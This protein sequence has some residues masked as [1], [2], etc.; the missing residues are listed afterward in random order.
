MSNTIFNRTKN[1]LKKATSSL[2]VNTKNR[3]EEKRWIINSKTETEP[4]FNMKDFNLKYEDEALK[5]SSYSNHKKWLS[6]FPISNGSKYYLRHDLKLGIL[7]SEQFFRTYEPVANTVKV[8]EKNYQNLD[9]RIDVLLIAFDLENLPKEWN[10]LGSST[11]DTVRNKLVK[12]INHFKKQSTKVIYYSLDES[13]IYKRVNSVIPET[14]IVLTIQKSSA[15]YFISENVHNNVHVLKLGFNPVIHNPIGTR[16]HK[17]KNKVALYEFW[18]PKNQRRKNTLNSFFTS[19]VNSENEVILYDSLLDKNDKT[20]IFPKELQGFLAPTVN[21]EYKYSYLKFFQSIYMF[22]EYKEKYFPFNRNLMEFMALGNTLITNYHS[23]IHN[24]YPNVYLGY[25]KTEIKE[26]LSKYSDNDIY[27]NQMAGVRNIF[28]QDTVFERFEELCSI[29]KIDFIKR[30]RKIAVIAKAKTD[31]VVEMFNYQTYPYKELILESELPKDIDDQYDMIAFFNDEYQYGEFYLE[32]LV[33]GFKYTFCD[34]I[35]K[36]SKQIK[37]N[38]SS[39][40]DHNYVNVL[41]DKYAT[42]FWSKSFTLSSL[43]TLENGAALSNGYMIDPFELE[44]K[45]ISSTKTANKKYKF[46]MIIPVYNNGLF[47]LNK[48][49]QSL[50]RSSM[51]DEM[52]ILIIDDG[53]TDNFTPNIVKRLNRQYEN[54]RCYFFNDGGSGSASRPRNKGIELITTEFITYLDPDNEAVNDGY[55]KLYNEISTNDFDMAVGNIY[56]VSDREMRLNFVSALKNVNNQQDVIEDT[57]KVFIEAAFKIASIQALLIRKSLIID[58]N[59]EMVVGAAG[60]DSLFFKEL[61]IFSKKIKLV[62][63]DIHIYYADVEGSV[64]NTI[65]ANFFKKYY[66]VQPYQVKFLKEQSLFTEYA[67]RRFEYYFKEWI[68]KKLM[69]VK[70]E[71]ALEAVKYS[72]QIWDYYKDYVNITEPVVA[73]FAELS[74]LKEYDKIVD[75]FVSAK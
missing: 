4:T 62:D 54:V 20:T 14:D 18:D 9:K 7:S 41:S 46:S 44:K 36:D 29:L 11:S 12:L 24:R 25:S 38:E 71:D 28:K 27:E 33:N 66:L 51:F 48:C 17:Y 19:A 34:Y 67:E 31:H 72:I 56:R 64:V 10:G 39:G 75:E 47:L 43:L 8:D 58:N 53:S 6:E 3:N 61:V 15:D 57:R 45:Y 16:L 69:Q 74:K 60:E 50:K 65:T 13:E 59:L 5:K 21:Y 23:D 49:F 2:L 63:E 52:E 55:A 32:D 40:T 70:H 1:I 22:N 37:G 30:E 73:R 26:I 42:L 68:L 35:S